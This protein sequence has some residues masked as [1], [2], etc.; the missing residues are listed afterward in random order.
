MTGFTIKPAIRSDAE[1]LSAFTAAVFR[2]TYEDDT[3]AADLDAYIG[4]NFGIAQQQAEIADPSGAV[5]LAVSEG[6]VIG[7][8]SVL[9]GNADA[10]TAFL[11]RLYVDAGWRGRGVAR[12]LLDAVLAEASLRSATRLELTVFEK[13]SRAIAFYRK[14]GFAVTGSTIFPVGEDMQTDIVMTRILSVA[15]DGA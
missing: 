11:N 4:E 9:I 1:T 13:N 15:A 12:D 2:A 5:F 7:C 10:E 6:Q 14:S 8:A 3:S